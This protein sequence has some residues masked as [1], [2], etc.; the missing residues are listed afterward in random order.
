MAWFQVNFFS[1]SLGRQ[2]GVHVLLPAEMPGP[3][4]ATGSE[5]AGKQKFKTLYLLHGYMGN[6]NDWL[7]NTQINELSQQYGL[8]V[9]M[10]SGDNGFYVDQ[11]TSGVKGAT[12]IGQ[13]LVEYTRKIFPLSEKR[14]DTIIAGLSMGGYGAIRNGLAFSDTF[15]HIIGLSSAIVINSI[16]GVGEEVNI[17]GVNKYYYERLFGDLDKV[18]FGINDPRS[19]AKNL[20]DEGKELPDLYFACGY[21]D[22][23]SDPNR[24]LHRYLDSIGFPHVYEEGPGTHEWP[25][26]RKF[27]ARGLERIFGKSAGGFINPFFVDNYDPE[28]DVIGKEEK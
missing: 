13:E 15:G 11:P 9:V 6:S 24:D 8:A 10:P 20:I 18:P 7:I 4:P 5:E 26:W 22:S 17:L 21:N 19:I 12:Y 2:V 16:K 23:L 1:V 14:E 3:I 28:F 25:F 27:I